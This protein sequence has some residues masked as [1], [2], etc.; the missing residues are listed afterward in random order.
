[1]RFFEDTVHPGKCLRERDGFVR[2]MSRACHGTFFIWVFHAKGPGSQIG[3]RGDPWV[4]GRQSAKT[5]QVKATIHR[6]ISR[7]G[8]PRGFCDS[9]WHGLRPSRCLKSLEDVHAV[10]ATVALNLCCEVAGDGT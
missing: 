6:D 3:G 8:P 9:L 4:L 2:T 10:W 5:I 7:N 1:M